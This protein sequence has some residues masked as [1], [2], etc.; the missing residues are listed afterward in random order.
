[1]LVKLSELKKHQKGT[2]QELHFNDTRFEQ[3][4]SWGIVEG[5][6]IERLSDG[7]FNDPIVFRVMECTIAIRLQDAHQIQVRI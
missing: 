1:M 3:M 2:I 6:T 5:S 4:A 7:I